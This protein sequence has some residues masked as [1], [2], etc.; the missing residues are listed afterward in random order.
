MRGMDPSL[1]GRVAVLPGLA[2]IA[3]LCVLSAG[4]TRRG[5]H[6]MADAQVYDIEKE[7]QFDKRWQLPARP[8]EADPRSRM[9]DVND[10]DATP[11]PLDD[12]GARPYQVSG[13]FPFEYHGWKK[14]GTTQ[15]ED[16]TWRDLI[17]REPDGSVKLSRESV[18][19]LALI[20]SRDYQFQFEDLYLAS[21]ALTLARFQF[22]V[23]GFSRNTLFFQ[24][25]GTNE[26]DSNQIQPGT[27]TGFT[28]NFASGAQL[29][30]DFAN[31]M[32]FEYNGKGFNTSLSSLHVALTQPLLRNAFARIA[33]QALS[34]QE[35]GVLY[36]LRDFSHFRRVF[37]VNTVASNGYLGLLQQLQALR[38]QESNIQALD[39]NVKEARALVEAE[40]SSILQR[41]LIDQ[42]YQ[43]ARFVLV[44]NEASLQTSLDAYKI[45]LGLPS[46]LPVKLDDSP[47]KLFELSDPKLDDLRSR[48][49][50][51]VLSLV[52]DDS[53]L[54]EPL[55]DI[56]AKLRELY[57]EL[58]QILDGAIT[59]S[60]RLVE[61]GQRSKTTV[62][63]DG[64]EDRERLSA[65]SENLAEELSVSKER[66][67][68]NLKALDDL[69]STLGVVDRKDSKKSLQRLAGDEYRARFAEVF[70][71]QSQ[72]RVF[73]I[74]LNP[75]ALGLDEAIEYA[76]GNRQDLMNALAQVTD[77][78]R[79][80]E[81]A[82]NQLLAGLDVVYDGVLGTDPKHDG[83]FR[84][85]S[86][87]STHRIG[88]RFDA[89]INRRAERNAYRASQI[90]YQR[91][92][93]NYM[94]VHDQVIFDIRLDMRNLG[95]AE[96]QFEIAR[97]SLI[98]AA[99]Q[100]DEAEY[101]VRNP[102]QE[103]QSLAL[104]LLQSLNGLLNS[105]NNLIAS[106]VSYETAR[107][108]L[109][110]DLD[111]MQ[112]DPRGVWTNEFSGTAGFPRGTRGA[113]GSGPA[114][115]PVRG[116]YGE[117]E[118]PPSVPANPG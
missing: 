28:K 79:N 86:S 85:D 27:D 96:R 80:E 92:R 55:P 84:F 115:D 13:A 36:T 113:E 4:C 24:H 95:L 14:R 9:R 20:H 17:P 108:S 32:V 61:K 107:M 38:N 74:D 91:A 2:F 101:N 62:E 12:K 112:I 78:W 44:Q 25:F 117:P 1:R 75:V 39:R 6:A 40:Q 8:V 18:M 30:V 97:E 21:L 53:P 105:R 16:L 57:V 104:N 98:I 49:D 60:A 81:F 103:T 114:V 3:L 102:G 45:Q 99:R 48:S 63:V 35:R 77:T 87:N 72:V 94:L 111:V 11:I 67:A 19:E 88:L 90:T 42:Q 47:L 31:N 83:I 110:R 54:S 71:T 26:T 34:I 59:E 41:D 46:D 33:T 56:A 118:A 106:W 109:Y 65:L 68:D 82:A 58:G 15:V 29:L 50:A 23:Q 100:V 66:L 22:S 89:P 5:Y 64:P 51:L 37:Y 7:R 43:Q 76:L 69:S 116:T 70:V 52:Q 93:R 10:P 73:L